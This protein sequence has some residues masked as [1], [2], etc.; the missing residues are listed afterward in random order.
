MKPSSVR[1]RGLFLTAVLLPTALLLF[2]QTFASQEQEPKQPDELRA[3]KNFIPTKVYTAEEDAAVLKLFEGLRVADICDGMDK[4][5]LK[6]IGLMDPEI[7]PLWKDTVSYSHRIVGIAVTAR[8]VPTNRPHT[9]RMETEAF[10]KWVSRW[11]SDYS[12]EPFVPLI[13]PGTVLVIED[14]P[15]A[16]VGTIGSNN[17]MA[18]KAAGC[19]GVVTNNTARD[20]DEII[21]EKIP[22]YLRNVGRGIRPG[23]NEIESVNRPIVCG[24]V[25]VRPGDVIAADGDGVIVVPREIAAEVAAYA[26][27]VLE[28]DKAARRQLYKKLNL[29]PDKSVE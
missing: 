12:S 3:G 10:T 21:T 27:S 15:G 6:N 14:A 18:W 29:P 28:E 7:H 26:K 22:L 5:G 17:I 24:S 13:R 2:S 16:D 4:A 11:Y 20:T 8:Y 25:L 23:R 1:P 19:V 9:A